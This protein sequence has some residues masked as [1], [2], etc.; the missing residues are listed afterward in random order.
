MEK[1]YITGM[2]G[3]GKTTLARI[4]AQNNISSIDIDNHDLCRWVNK[5][6]GETVH[7][8]PGVDKEFFK[9]NTSVCDVEKLFKMIEEKE[10]PVFVF[11]LVDNQKD[12][13][14]K[15]DKVFLLRCDPKILLERINSRTDND[16][17]K[18]EEAQNMIIRGYEKFENKM[19]DLGAIP[20]D[21]SM[22]IDEVYGELMSR[23]K[24]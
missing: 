19:F 2:S 15:F 20:I 7:R 21:T 4:L 13:F 17:G 24:E 16:F 23:I 6:T 11:G 3:N 9:N 1:Y 8:Q 5:E 22:P 10:S 12:F 18:D 14:D